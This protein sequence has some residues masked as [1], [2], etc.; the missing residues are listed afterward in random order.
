MARVTLSFDNGP[1][2]SITHAILDI[3]AAR[4]VR[5]SFFV[6]GGRLGA[7]AARDAVRRAHDEGHWIGNHTFTHSTPLGHMRSA[8]AAVDEIRRTDAAL[9][10]IDRAVP[11]YGPLFRPF[12]FA[13]PRGV[14]L[15]HPAAYDY[16]VETG[17]SVVVWSD[18]PGDWGNPR[19][20]PDRALKHCRTREWSLLA[21]HDVEGAALERLDSFIAALRD[22]GFE[23]VQDFPAD[24]VPLRAG[25]PTQDMSAYMDAVAP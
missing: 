3:L 11:G 25:T 9:D 10:F 6:L 8:R 18:A 13:R 22:E 4:D 1:V 16:L 14:H 7:D 19:G 17:A 24:C 12:G 21:L 20:W 23:I 15:L 2:P 5:A